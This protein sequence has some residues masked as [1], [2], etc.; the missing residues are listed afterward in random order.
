MFSNLTKV[1]L[2]HEQEFK[3]ACTSITKALDYHYIDYAS[4]PL[5][6]MWFSDVTLLTTK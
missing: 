4:M 5:P 2:S 3:S 6:G 1:I